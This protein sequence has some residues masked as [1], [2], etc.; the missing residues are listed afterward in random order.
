MRLT[1]RHETAYRFATSPSSVI[2]TLRMTPR[3]HDGQHIVRWRLDVDRNCRVRASE[4]AFGNITHTFAVDGPIESLTVLAEGEIDTQD[5]DGIIRHTVERFSPGLYLRDTALTAPDSAIGVFAEEAA[6]ASDGTVLGKLHAV[7]DELHETM[8]FDVSPTDSATTA[9]EAFRIK[10]GVCQ[11]L[12]HVFIVAARHLGVPARYVSGYFRRADDVLQQESGHA[13]AE[14]FVPDL[15]WIGFDPANGQC[16][17]DAYARVAI[18]LDYLGAAPI[19][20][21]RYGGSGETL[22]VAVIVED[23]RGPRAFR[24]S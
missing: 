20:G 9:A 1:I 23:A 10:R 16:S 24:R 15:G 5:T 21:S 19:R 14:A 12:T 13:W 11:D 4:D 18:G 8:T 6:A 3:G 17:T 2:Q 7:L 22:T